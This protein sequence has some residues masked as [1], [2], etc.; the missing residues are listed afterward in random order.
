MNAQ[1][2]F[3]VRKYYL[4]GCCPKKAHFCIGLSYIQ[5]VFAFGSPLSTEG[6]SFS[7]K[8]I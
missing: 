1:R 4:I 5:I 7:T 6:I 3:K 2:F 8:P